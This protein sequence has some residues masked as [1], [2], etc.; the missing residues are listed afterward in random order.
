MNMKQNRE[1]LNRVVAIAVLT[2]MILGGQTVFAKAHGST[3]GYKVLAER[4]LGVAKATSM[5]LR[6]DQR[7][8]K[9]LY[10]AS[11]AG[12]LSILDVSDPREPRKVDDLRLTGAESNFRVRPVSNRIALATR[13]ADS[14]EDLTI[15][16]LGNGPSA[17]VAHQFKN[18]EAYTLDG[19]SNTAYVAAGGE[20]VVM[21]FDH[22][23]THDAEIWEES[24]ENR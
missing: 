15:V 21:R 14:A 1:Q 22:P 4:N 24:Y 10:V 23:I 17:S 20:L 2:A 6:Q 9:F 8:H 18:A 5:F 7:G 13:T 3:G 16:D 12:V 19:A 11:D